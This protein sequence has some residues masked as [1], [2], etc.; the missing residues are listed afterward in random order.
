[1]GRLEVFQEQ[2]EQWVNN[3]QRTVVE[4]HSQLQC[5]ACQGIQVIVEK[6]FQVE[7]VDITWKEKSIEAQVDNHHLLW[8]QN[9]F[10]VKE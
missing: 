8:D 4:G 1:M 7:S 10:S 9:I 5:K 6:T 2:R 3:N